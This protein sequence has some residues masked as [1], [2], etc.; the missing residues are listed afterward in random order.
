[1]YLCI[2]SAD[3]NLHPVTVA[4]DDHTAEPDF[5]KITV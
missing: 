2:L 5:G 4:V 1:M 3:K